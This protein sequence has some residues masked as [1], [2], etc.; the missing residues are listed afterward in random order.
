LISQYEKAVNLLFRLFVL[1]AVALLPA[2][3][4]QSHNE[5][6]LRHS[7]ET[8]VQEQALG[9]ARISAAEIQ[10]IVE[11][12]HNVLVA[13]SE[14]RVIK[15]RDMEACNTYLSAVSR[16][17]PA[18]PS[19][20]V[21]DT[22]G[23]SWCAT[24][25]QQ[26]NI[27]GRPYFAE[28]MKTGQFTIGEF[29]VG[30]MTRRNVIQFALPFYGADGR[31]AGVIVA[32][33]NLDWL[34]TFIA[35]LSVPAGTA[36]SIVDRNGTYLARSPQNSQFV[37]RR[38][39]NDRY[40]QLRQPGTIA[41]FD[42]DGV[43]RVIGSSAVQADSD[44]LLVTVGLDRK[45][46]FG[47]IK[48]RTELGLVLIALSTSLVLFLTGWGV[49]RF[50]HEPLGRLTDAA[51]QLRLGDYTR[52]VKVPD[53]QP[54]IARVADAFNSMADVLQQHERDLYEAKERAEE[55]AIRITTIFES[56]ID[57]VVTIDQNWRITYMNERARE[58]L[59]GGRNV[60]GREFWE[61]F[62]DEIEPD[63][64]DLIRK[65]MSGQR[66]SC[67][68]AYCLPRSTWY[69]INAFPSGEGL[70]IL[71]RDVTD[72]RRAVEARRRMEEELHQ[73]QKMEAVGLL[74]GG[75]AHDFNNLLMI[76]AGN[77]EVIE[78]R[79]TDHECV[80][81]LAAIARKAAD[82]GAAVTG[83]L[84]AFSRRQELNP[85][86]VHAGYLIK[87]FEELIRRALGER[88]ELKISADEQLWPC[89]VDPAQLQTALLNLTVNGRDAMPDGGVLEIEARNVH[90]ADQAIGVEA[91]SYVKISLTDTGCG[92]PPEVLDRAFEPFFT[93]KDVGRGTGLGLSM[94]YGFVRQSHGQVTI[95][96]TPGSGT[97]V[98]LYLPRSS[99]R[100]L[101]ADRPVAQMQKISAESGRV[102]LVE[103]D[104]D[105][106]DVT[107]AMLD[108]LG[109]QVVC[110][111]SGIEA[112]RLLK[113]GED[114]DL[115]LT[116]VLMPQGVNGIE[117]AR[118][119][120]RIRDGIKVLLV[121]GNAADVL[122]AHGAVD[123][124]PV[125]GKPFRRSELAQCL[126]LVLRDA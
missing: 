39:P 13:L 67:L 68:E 12:V 85:R 117:L 74:T 72:H 121:S 25:G 107:S 43:E 76:I 104:D 73:A 106:L 62:K 69:E 75:V 126:Q 118:E 27:A 3:A 119:A 28:A 36:L 94:V 4:I 55:A 50:I 56:T 110:A 40:L 105:V 51:N 87:D 71:L 16:R 44:G 10:Q 113:A 96:S 78:E 108:K 1:V 14:L 63:V 65:A 90:L 45:R 15:G 93:T 101:E 33:L 61:T 48:R 115:L 100:R 11:G 77:L 91:G 32:P 37:S 103:D 21:V 2:I 34:A 24:A 88:C 99:W 95:K 7:R 23:Q 26:T 79:A 102:L 66:Q 41:A 46:A 111:R 42:L 124:F 92:M 59:V 125:I 18:F 8:E 47:G 17:Y 83:Q 86:P 49:R 31:L 20:V 35:Q 58:Q 5:F 38:M 19:F 123:E 109:Y 54:E 60:V 114:F 70:A 9:L 82:R 81:R 122:A 80:R 52:R 22:N 6:D 29:S 89:D 116:D 97:T 84:L 53:S 64:G 30:R 120:R 112:I 57:C 98:S